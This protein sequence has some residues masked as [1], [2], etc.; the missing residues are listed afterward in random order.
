MRPALRHLL[1]GASASAIGVA[2]ACG[3]EG[4]SLDLFP[5]RNLVGDVAPCNSA[6][7]CPDNRPYCTGGLCVECLSDAEC[8]GN[9]PACLAG[10][11]VT[12]TGPEHC[13]EGSACNVAGDRCAPVCRGDGGCAGATPRCDDSRGFCVECVDDAECT[14]R[15]RAVCDTAAGQCVAC[16]SDDECSGRTPA[17]DRARH[18]CVECTDPSYCDGLACDNERRCVEC[19]RD[20][21][22][23]GGG[24]CDPMGRCEGGCASD[25]AEDAGSCPPAPRRP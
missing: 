12:C 5:R 6:L 8:R 15:E 22:C 7:D 4:R 9:R 14:T 17:C 1:L 18:Q 19:N 13:P 16:N 23:P 11:C 20:A 24:R 25:A 3:Y 21:D 10:V 2:A